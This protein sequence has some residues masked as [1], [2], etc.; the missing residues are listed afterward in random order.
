MLTYKEWLLK[1]IG[2]NLPIGDIAAE[3]E[4]DNE[5]PNSKDYEVI[6]EFVE[7]NYSESF[8]RVF[9]YSFKMFYDSTQKKF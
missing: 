5:F 8:I 7:S 2:V 4:L 9:E 3:V 6:R 1:F